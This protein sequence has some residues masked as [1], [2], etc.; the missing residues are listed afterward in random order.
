FVFYEVLSVST[1]PLVAH[2]GTEEAKRSG[3]IYLGILLSTSIGFL[4]FG[5]I[6]TW[7]IAG[8]LDFVRGGVFNAEQAQGPMIAVLL[9]LYAFGIGKAA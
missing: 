8:T 9:A 5:M 2:H 1:F 4:L 6:W 3:R 7:Q